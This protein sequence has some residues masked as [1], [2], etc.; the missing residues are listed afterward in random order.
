MKTPWRYSFFKQLS[1]LLF[2]LLPAISV[3]AATVDL[4]V[5]YDS[6]TR[7]YYGG[8]VTTAIQGWVNEVNSFHQNSGT[9]IQVRL[10]GTMEYDPGGNDMGAVL[11]RLHND[12]WVRDRRNETGADFVTQ[13][14]RTGNCG[15]GYQ[16]VHRDWAFNVTGT[17][18]GGQV[19][20]HELG[21]NMGLAHSRRQGD[22]GGARYRYGIGYGV[23][24]VFASIMAYPQVFNAPW[25]TRF[26][27]PY[28][29]CNGLPCGIPAGRS[30][31]SDASLALIQVRDEI[32][33]FMPTH[34]SAQPAFLIKNRYS[35][36]CLDVGGWSTQNGANIIQWDCHGGDNQ[37]F[38]IYDAGGGY[39]YLQAKNSGKCLDVKDWAMWP[40]QQIVQWD[41]H[42]GDN[43]KLNPANLGG[44]LFQMAFK[45]SGI[46]L[47]MAGWSRDN[48]GRAIQW[49]CH[50]GDNQRFD[51]VQVE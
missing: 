2:L 11:D 9:G 41:C 29:S 46:C 27:S 21:H 22:T 40:G 31:E 35:G 49:N 4:L 16:A 32:A 30:D 47:D 10:V 13:V 28:A 42:G 51:F 25:M 6:Y 45:N 18:C 15:L 34:A 7:N 36:K 48:G 19:L 12:A 43:Q 17:T 33:N 39:W 1:L 3:H 14:H 38:R 24:G 37:R 8:G 23:D 20:A 5:L 50:A 44:M 26:S